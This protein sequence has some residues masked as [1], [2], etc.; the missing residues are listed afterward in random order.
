MTEK[1]SDENWKG[2]LYVYYTVFLDLQF[3]IPLVILSPFIFHSRIF[4]LRASY[5]IHA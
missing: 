2:I 1:S 5:P 3:L 4:L